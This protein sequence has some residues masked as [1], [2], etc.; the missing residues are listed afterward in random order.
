MNT[1]NNRTT[2]ILIS[3][4]MAAVATALFLVIPITPTFLVAYAVA[5]LAI[6]MFCCG[7]LFLISNK[8]I[9]PWVAAFP[10]TIWQYLVTQLILSA[11]FVIRA[12]LFDNPFPL[13]VFVF[14]HIVLFAFFAVLLLL[15]RSGKEIITEKD[16]EV[17]QKVSV[18][19]MMQ[20][21]IE[22][23]MRQHPQHEAIL[24]KVAE[25]LKYSDPMSHP[26]VAIYDEP[27]QRS[28]MSMTGLEGNDPANIPAICETLLNQ[29]ADRNSRVK[30]MK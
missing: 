15:L 9:Y 1:L 14:L 22:S 29:I 2:V 16:A 13:G 6:A 30:L 3:A 26:S 4:I 18:I 19:R 10:M 8:K 11:V 23:I 17:K 24:K 7:K 12:T 28:I 27:I 20:A 25:A 21:D 5:L